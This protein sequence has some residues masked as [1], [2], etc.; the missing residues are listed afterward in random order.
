MAKE[1]KFGTEARAKIL[2]GVDLLANAVKVT[3]GPKGRNV[4]LE[5][6]FGAP[7]VTKDGVS[8]A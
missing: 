2:E 7:R 6:S 8:V 4:V 1:I 5:K 3:L